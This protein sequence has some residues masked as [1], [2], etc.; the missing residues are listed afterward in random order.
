MTTPSKHN[1]QSDSQ[2]RI[3][4]QLPSDLFAIESLLEEL[5]A[6]DRAVASP[7]DLE[8]RVT[9][10]SLQHLRAELPNDLEVTART[11]DHLGQAEQQRMSPAAITRI[12]EASASHLPSLAPIPIVRHL[13]TERPAA[14][15]TGQRWWSRRITRVAAVLVLGLG[16]TFTILAVRQSNLAESRRIAAAQTLAKNVDRSIDEFFDS[17]S[18]H[19]SFDTSDYA[20]DDL[21]DYLNSKNSDEGAS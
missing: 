17:S 1:S 20:L 3:E 8:A 18:E 4:G 5:A 2:R 16:A 12:T 7:H 13:A 19:D 6:E 14:H 9:A 11:A 21:D 15:S 10:M